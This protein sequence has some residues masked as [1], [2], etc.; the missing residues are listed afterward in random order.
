MSK[1]QQDR[2][3]RR[4]KVAV[5]A[6]KLVSA[7][8]SNQE[9]RDKI[10]EHEH[11]ADELR[12]RLRVAEA[13]HEYLSR[14]L[15]Q[16][17]L[18]IFVVEGDPGQNTPRT[19]YANKVAAEQ[20]NITAEGSDKA[21]QDLA[22]SGANGFQAGEGELAYY[23]TL[24]TGEEVNRQEVVVRYAAGSERTF[25]QSSVILRNS[26]NSREVMTIL[27][28]V[29]AR[30]QA[31][32]YR[33]FLAT[34]VDSS[35]EAIIGE[36][37]DGTIISWNR[38]A[39]QI[40]GYTAAE[41]LGR[42]ISI[43][44]PPEMCDQLPDI[45]AFVRQGGVHVEHKATRIT[46]DGRRIDT[47]SSAFPILDSS[48]RVIQA[49]SICRDITEFSVLEEFRLAKEVAEIANRTKSEYLSRMSHELRTPLNA[50]IGFAQLLEMQKHN[51]QDAEYI[52]IIV[53]CG[54]HLLNLINDMLD[55]AR[56]EAGKLG[57]SLEPVFVEDILI[58][59]CDLISPMS[60]QKG[61]PLIK[62]ISG[63]NDVLVLADQQRLK[64]ILLNYLSNAIKYNNPGVEISIGYER[65]P[66][67]M[68]RILV[69]DNGAGI[70]SEKLPLLFSAFERL[71]AERTT[72]EG[73]GLGL[74][75]AR[76]LAEAMGGRV[77]VDSVVGRGSVFWVELPETTA[78]EKGLLEQEEPNSALS[79][80]TRA[81]QGS[82]CC[83]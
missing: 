72:I 38:G 22:I 52:E 44:F 66:D 67:G 46:K 49:G 35:D 41:A 55:I 36:A 8:A 63:S 37:F 10:A 16:L 58:E 28:D 15:E 51:A 32:Q 53:S 2:L 60:K 26:A 17:P 4:Q 68:L 78:E 59:S 56:I 83:I 25:Q 12:E 50:I 75:I 48:N 57:L 7:E 69:A 42:N 21:P 11:I 40:Y 14:M 82:R 80:R 39:E 43:L 64:Q 20:L 54:R 18:G 81:R 13:G 33:A 70:P 47:S 45:L 79:F 9:L 62:K 3:P 74:T 65:R 71:G 34:I 30:K 76:Q 61:N 29:T 19:L 27:E 1:N 24:R 23:K 73:T 77:G 5:R 31:E 6:R